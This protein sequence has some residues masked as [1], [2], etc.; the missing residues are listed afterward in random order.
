MTRPRPEPHARPVRERR[1]ASHSL[2]AV[3]NAAVELPEADAV[4][5]QSTAEHTLENPSIG[6]D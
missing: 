5:M 1:R 2:E 4:L 3:L 6:G